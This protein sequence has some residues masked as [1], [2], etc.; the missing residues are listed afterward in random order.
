ME[1]WRRSDPGV[2]PWLAHKPRQSWNHVSAI[3]AGLLLGRL[4]D[5]TGDK[6][7]GA[8]DIDGEF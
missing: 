8:T 2:L 6:P 4:T 5:V 3:P 7:I 1:A